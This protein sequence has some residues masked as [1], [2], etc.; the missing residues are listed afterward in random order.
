M[1]SLY[2]K[3]RKALEQTILTAVPKAVHHILNDSALFIKQ[4]TLSAD[5]IIQ[6]A[7]K[8]IIQEKPEVQASIQNFNQKYP[9]KPYDSASFG[10]AP[11]TAAPK[12]AIT[13]QFAQARTP[14]PPPAKQPTIAPEPKAPSSHK[15]LR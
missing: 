3:D 12:Q 4:G 5:T 10:K 9:D 2:E 6:H 13:T 15:K 14:N 11:E 7:V 8:H 1:S